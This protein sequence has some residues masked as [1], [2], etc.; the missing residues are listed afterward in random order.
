MG[1]DGLWRRIRWAN[2]GRLAGLVALALLAAA[3]PAGGDRGAA[4]GRRRA[5]RPGRARRPPRPPSPRTCARE[6]IATRAEREARVSGEGPR[7]RPAPRA[8]RAARPQAP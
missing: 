5:V 8:Q 6:G 2:V 3:W 7:A 1:A 4:R